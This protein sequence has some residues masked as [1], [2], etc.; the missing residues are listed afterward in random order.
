MNKRLK[1]IVKQAVQKFYEKDTELV[2]IK[3]MEQLAFLG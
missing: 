3:G 2:Q 1:N